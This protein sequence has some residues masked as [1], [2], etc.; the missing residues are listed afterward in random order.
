[1][2]RLAAIAEEERKEQELIAAEQYAAAQGMRRELMQMCQ[3]ELD[4]QQQAEDSCRHQRD[5]ECK[6]H[7]Q[8]EAEAAELEA[9]MNPSHLPSVENEADINSFITE[10]AVADNATDPL[11]E[12][13]V[14]AEQVLLIAS[15]LARKREHVTSC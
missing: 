7:Q 5:I 1:M 6:R 2:E 14:Q 12:A 8:K 11:K 13:V 10:L 9:F 4:E 15:L 3:E